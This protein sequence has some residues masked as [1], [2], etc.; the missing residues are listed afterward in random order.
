[1]SRYLRGALVAAGATTALAV[2]LGLGLGL[3]LGAFAQEGAPT[4]PAAL[5]QR[6]YEQARQAVGRACTVDRDCP[7]PLRCS[8]AACVEP[9]G[10]V[11]GAD[12]QTPMVLFY[13][14]GGEVAYYVEVVDD[15]HE[16][17]RGLMYRPS[18]LPDWGMLFVYPDER[19]L[20]FWMQNTF[21][22]LDM[23]FLDGSGVVVGVVENAEPLTTT[24]RSVPGQ[25][26]FVVE[27]NG[28]QAAAHG[29]GVGVRVELL[30]VPAEVISAALGDE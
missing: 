6:H 5:A 24:S 25:S 23:V 26:Q 18:L 16:R 22:P 3:G 4:P 30:N 7:A 17:A 2:A 13:G 12:G 19:P 11:G 1:M 27:L 20:S 10:I 9:A 14:S 8:E 29:I 15:P 28:G 21:I